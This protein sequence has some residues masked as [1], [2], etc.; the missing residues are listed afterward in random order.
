MRKYA[1]RE[2]YPGAS[3]Q[4]ITNYF[5]LLWGIPISGAVL[6]IFFVKESFNLPPYMF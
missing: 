4:N 2:Q 5:T 6:E 3:Q 1:Y